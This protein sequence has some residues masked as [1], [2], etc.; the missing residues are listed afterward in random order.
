[1]AE[2]APRSLLPAIGP[3]RLIVVVG[4]SGA[5]KDTLLGLARRACADDEHILFARRVVTRESSD[6]EDNVYLAPQAF[7]EAE[8][9]GAFAVQWQ[10][11]GH[12][13][14]LPRAI[15]DALLAGHTVVA[16]VSRTVIEP[17]RRSYE[18]VEVVTITAPREVLARRLAARGRA[19]DGAL[20]QR[21]Q[22]EVASPAASDW[23]IVNVGSVERNAGELVR[24]IRGQS[25]E[26][27]A[28]T[29]QAKPAIATVEELEAIYGPDHHAAAEGCA[30]LITPSSRRLIEASPVVMVTTV[31]TAGLDCSPHADVPGFVRIHDEATLMIPDA[32]G[33][34]RIDALRNIVRDPRVALL[35]IIPGSGVT[36]RVNGKA[37]IFDDRALLSSF[38]VVGKLPRTV[39]VLAVE[40]VWFQSAPKIAQSDLWNAK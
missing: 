22:R 33:G 37:R 12:C 27:G 7:A 30:R 19:S 11:H 31:G 28:L 21:L 35:F 26:S 8:E 39:I 40:E 13:Y 9:R 38:D 14:G 34:E 2:I 5:G 36:L 24:L 32:G 10:A 15:D 25:G 20:D 29:G 6:F 18:S 1:M 16:N 17:L 23:T 4:P 3:G